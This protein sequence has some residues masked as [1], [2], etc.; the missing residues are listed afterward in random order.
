MEKWRFLEVDWL[1]YAETG[2]YRQAL[3][4]AVTEG[5]VPDTVSFCTFKDPS[6]IITYF[7]DP[8]KEINLQ[9]CREKGIRVSRLVIGGGPIFGD[10][11]YVI[12]FL[13][14]ARRNPKLPEDAEK[15]L[16]KTLTGV[17]EGTR[18]AFG[19]Q[20]R[21]RPLNDLEVLCE[22]GIWRKIGPSGCLY[23]KEAIQ[24]TSGIQ[25]KE[26]DVNLI[27]SIITPPPEKF[28]DKEAK[29]IKER[30]TY[31]ERVAG[32]EIDLDEL[33]RFY[34]D[35][36]QK[37][38]QVELVPGELTGEEREYIR[39]M[40]EEYTS[41]EFFMERSERKFGEIPSGVSRKT[42]QFKVPEGSFVRVI[43][44][45]KG[46]R[47]CNLLINGMIH[48]SPLRPAS[49]IHEIERALEGQPIDRE[50]FESKIEEVLN[51]PGFHLPRISSGLLA[52]KIYECAIP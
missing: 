15:M 44:F 8:E 18:D 26:N 28:R 22:N 48:A 32:R 3:M 6:L 45:V 41:E 9:L 42:I 7:N 20:C 31:L 46:D 17:A 5:L 50:I 19:V 21:F 4:R 52:S 39:E 30:I 51:R 29:T 27:E 10:T 35:R 34:K 37:I 47:L 1:T 13:H 23:Q 43:A 11:G 14:I 40:E 49:P 24:M 36:I 38:F 33:K 12:T 2:I 25:V 16:K